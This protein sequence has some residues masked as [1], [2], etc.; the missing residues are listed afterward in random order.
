METCSDTVENVV[1][2]CVFVAGA[3]CLLD[4]LCVSVPDKRRYDTATR[5]EPTGIEANI[6]GT[7]EALGVQV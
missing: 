1:V 7:P 6:A 5:L 3:L 4:V 2:D